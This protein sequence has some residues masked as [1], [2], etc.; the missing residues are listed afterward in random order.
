MPTQKR[1]NRLVRDLYTPRM[2][3]SGSKSPVGGATLAHWSGEKG[4]CISPDPDI[5]TRGTA[6]FPKTKGLGGR[7]RR[8]FGVVLQQEEEEGVEAMVG[9][10]RKMAAV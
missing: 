2:Q 3:I 9:G 4:A 7:S 10:W 1:S 6:I 8:P 5:R